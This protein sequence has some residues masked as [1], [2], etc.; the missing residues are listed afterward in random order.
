MSEYAKDA[1]HPSLITELLLT[2]R[3]PGRGCYPWDVTPRE[4]IE[5]SQAEMEQPNQRSVIN[6]FCHAKR[7]IHGHVD[8]LL[9]NCERCL[10]NDSFR[11]TL[12]GQ[13]N[14]PIVIDGLWG[15]AFGNGFANQPVN[16]LFYAAGPNDEANGLYGRIDA[17]ALSGGDEADD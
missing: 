15:L 2:S 11:G 12:R 1:P 17:S 10:R 7:A 13:D 6:A 4:Y 16:T 9:H 5:F 8:F 3:T 14:H